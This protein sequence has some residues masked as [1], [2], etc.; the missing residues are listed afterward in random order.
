[1][2]LQDHVFV[3]VTPAAPQ[4]Q[5]VW[6]PGFLAVFNTDIPRLAWTRYDKVRQHADARDKVERKKPLQITDV[7]ERPVSLEQFTL[8]Q[9]VVP[10]SCVLF[11]FLFR[12]GV[13][14]SFFL[15]P[16]CFADFFFVSVSV[17]WPRF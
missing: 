15:P 7:P 4:Q 14:V 10:R 13:S 8:K 11:S 5:G 9:V 6:I 12:L 16:V 1:M 2:Y 3:F 17:F